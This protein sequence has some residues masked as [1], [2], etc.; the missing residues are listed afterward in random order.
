MFEQNQFDL[1]R[2]DC[3]AGFDQGRMNDL[4]HETERVKPAGKTGILAFRFLALP[5]DQQA[6]KLGT[7]RLIDG[8]VRWW[9]VFSRL[10]LGTEAQIS[11]PI[12]CRLERFRS[13][14]RQS[15]CTCIRS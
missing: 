3:F 10:I 8:T 12:G 2:S 9:S 1:G 6:N 5:G 13:D 7:N 11:S 14:R 4:I 15:N